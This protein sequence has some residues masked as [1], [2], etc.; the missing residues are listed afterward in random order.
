MDVPNQVLVENRLLAALTPGDAE[1][2]T[3][4]ELVR[5]A[6]GE[7]L[8]EAGVTINHIYFPFDCL[9]SMLAVCGPRQTLEVG[10]VGAEGIVGIAAILGSRLSPVRAVAFKAGI[11]ARMPVAQCSDA[12]NR[13]PDWRQLINRAA[14]TLLA[15]AIQVAAC[16]RSHVLEARLARSLLQIRDRLQ[17]NEFHVTHEVFSQTLG[18]R[19]VGVTKAA[20]TLQQQKLISYTR[21]DIKIL[22]AKGLERA[23][24]GCYDIVNRITRGE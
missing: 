22:D 3:D 11:A 4:I 7:V 16:N 10:L 1:S 21:G 18:V 9:I 5:L 14:N 13:Q 12:Y 23:S 2:K 6:S 15:H 24:C 17:T 19:R 8:Y 20:S